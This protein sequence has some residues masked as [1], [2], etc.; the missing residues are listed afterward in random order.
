M[1]H[2][3]DSNS[4]VEYNLNVNNIKKMTFKKD[5]KNILTMYFTGERE[6]VF[7]LRVKLPNAKDFVEDIQIMMEDGSN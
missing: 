6:T 5:D 4:V 7:F 2:Q 1:C 3:E